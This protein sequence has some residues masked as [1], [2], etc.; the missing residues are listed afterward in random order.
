M[1]KMLLFVLPLFSGQ[2]PLP[3]S[4]TADVVTVSARHGDPLESVSVDTAVI[5]VS[6]SFSLGELLQRSSA[7]NIKN[8]GRGAE[9]TAV[10]R[11]TSATHTAVYWNGLKINSPLTGAV[12]FS[13]IPM[14]MVDRVSVEA[15]ISGDTYG[16][17]AIGGTI[18][19][20]NEP[21][22]VGRRPAG[23]VS[24]GYGSFGTAEGYAELSVGNDRIKSSSRIY[25]SRSRNDF[26]FENRDIF[27]PEK[28]GW[29]PTQKNL[30][31]DYSTFGFMQQIWG[32]L[33]DNQTLSA[34]VW[35]TG[36]IRNLPQLTAWEGEENSNLTDTRDRALRANVEY[37]NYGRKVDFGISLGGALENNLFEKNNRIVSGYSRYIDTR[38]FSRLGQIQGDVT[39]RIDPR[40]S[41]SSLTVASYTSAS[42]RDLLYGEGYDKNRGEFSETARFDAKWNNWL[43]TTVMGRAGIVDDEGYLLPTA[44]V[45]FMVSDISSFSLRW[46]MNVHFPTLSDLWY[47]P[48]GNSDLRSEKSTTAELGYSLR[49]DK[50]RITA[51]AYYSHI[52]D[53]ILWLPTA[54]QYWTPTNILNV[55]AFGLETSVD[56]H[57]KWGDWSLQTSGNLTINITRSQETYGTEQMPYVP[58]VSYSAYIEAGWKGFSLAWQGYGESAKYASLATSSTKTDVI[59]GYFLQDITLGYRFKLIRVEGVCRNILDDR[60]YGVLRRPMAPR[61]FEIRLR[62]IF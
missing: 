27:D 1:I 61:S 17:G 9:Q 50:F 10:F 21:G 45:N 56:K 44:A 20:K 38:G 48:G 5:A 28:P 46:D 58:P 30:H 2:G 40:F 4:I 26:T 12:D 25:A 32:K 47:I 54:Q 22:E 39:W 16:A 11:G 59:S 13:L 15:G 33:A 14:E 57:W 52:K 62:L 3:D 37:K 29:H 43:N 36:D 55:D 24:A 23:K 31:A 41:I 35:G 60:Y 8:Y 18:T 7:V 51:T 19:L 49:K 34:S 53:W 42:S 6:K